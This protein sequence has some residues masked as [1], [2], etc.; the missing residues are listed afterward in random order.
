MIPN[1][2]KLYKNVSVRLCGKQIYS[3]LFFCFCSLKCGTCD[4]ME[5][6]LKSEMFLTDWKKPAHSLDMMLNIFQNVQKLNPQAPIRPCDGLLTHSGMH[7]AF[8]S[9][10]PS[11]KDIYK[12]RRGKKN[13]SKKS[14][15]FRMRLLQKWNT[16]LRAKTTNLCMLAWRDGNESSDSSTK[17]WRNSSSA[18]VPRG[19]LSAASVAFL[20]S[21]QWLWSNG[22]HCSPVPATTSR[23]R[24]GSLGC[25]RFLTRYTLRLVV[26]DT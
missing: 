20:P 18:T 15:K 25:P 19:L 8:S 24:D 10:L 14:Q 22:R 2:W 6:K 26:S 16:D 12:S 1:W 23:L 11:P 3:T 9:L 21:P 17:K 7:P 5:H 13:N 4:E